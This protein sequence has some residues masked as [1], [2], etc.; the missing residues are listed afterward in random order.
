MCLSV[1]C[2][3]T[4]PGDSFSANQSEAGGLLVGGGCQGMIKDWGLVSKMTCRSEV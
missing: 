4:G 3:K 1:R 2:H